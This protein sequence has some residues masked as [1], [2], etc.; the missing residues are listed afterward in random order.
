[1]NKETEEKAGKIG[2]ENGE[3]S[4]VRVVLIRFC[5]LCIVGIHGLCPS[6]LSSPMVPMIARWCVLCYCYIAFNY[7]RDQI[8]I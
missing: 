4:A 1:M 7:R 6:G 2:T 8:N 3:E 5:Y